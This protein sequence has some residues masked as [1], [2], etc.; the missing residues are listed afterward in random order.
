M[1]R[2]V[3]ND[4]DSMEDMIAQLGCVDASK[5]FVKAR[6]Y[7]EANHDKE[8]EEDRP[9]DITAKEWKTLIQ[10]ADVEDDFFEGEEEDLDFDDDFHVTRLLSPGGD[11]PSDEEEP[12]A[13]KP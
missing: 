7:F 6:E 9:K 3:G 2:G 4:Y 8:P 12:P 11:E 13:K 10:E 1:G 5:A